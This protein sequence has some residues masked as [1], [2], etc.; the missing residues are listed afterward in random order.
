MKH[1]RN[2]FTR[3]GEELVSVSSGMVAD[4]ATKKD[5]LTAYDIGEANFLS[6]VESRIDKKEV[7][8]FAPIKANKLRTFAGAKRPERKKPEAL[9]HVEAD[10]S[11]FAKLALVAKERDI[12]MKEILCYSLSPV[13]GCMASA[14]YGSM[15]KTRKAQLLAYLEESIPGC[16]VEKKPDNA[17]LIIDA[18]TLIRSEP[19][20]TLPDRFGAFAKAIF[21]SVTKLSKQYN[22]TRVDL[23]GDRYDAVSIKNLERA[24][25]HDS[26]QEYAINNGEQKLPVKWDSYLSSGKNKQALQAF[27]SLQLQDFT[28]THN[29]TLVV[30]LQQQVYELQYGS[31]LLPVRRDV[32]ELNSDHEE[33]DTRMLLHVKHAAETHQN[34]ILWTTDTDV[35]AIAIGQNSQISSNILFATGTRLKKRM[36]NLSLMAESLGP[37]ADHLPA[38]HALTGCDTCSSFYNKGKKTV[39]KLVRKRPDLIGGLA[40]IGEDWNLC[41]IPDGIESLICALYGS[42]CKTVN[43]AR[44]NIFRTGTSD[45]LLPP[46]NDALL[47]HLKRVNYQTRVWKL[48]LQPEIKPPSPVGKGWEMDGHGNLDIKWLEE[49]FA[50]PSV[51]KVTKCSC[52]TGCAGRCS[53]HKNNLRCTALCTCTDC[54]NTVTDNTV[55]SDSESSDSRDDDME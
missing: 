7:D 31:N 23:V 46:N 50:P 22:A 12:S 43:E 24:R 34:T 4:E 55:Q 26:T 27:I 20:A 6:F 37:L 28:S 14:D 41:D 2:P 42:K 32:T 48:A 36:I 49:S 19:A 17:A 44:Y 35:V 39:M 1:Y 54:S 25:R 29:F 53:C 8:F 38:L 52:K 11:L 13:P 30:A 51:L 40:A 5:L 15:A 3:D 47:Q 18:M 21:N 45:K 16:K 33:A 9:Q 10:R